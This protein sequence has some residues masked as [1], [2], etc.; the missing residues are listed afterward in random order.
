MGQGIEPRSGDRLADAMPEEMLKQ[1]LDGFAA[2]V[3]QGIADAPS[4]A[5]FVARYC[6]A[7]P[8]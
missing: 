3:V 5:D 1:R 2:S 6:P 7:A 8:L 4:H